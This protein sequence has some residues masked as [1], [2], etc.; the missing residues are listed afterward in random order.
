[1]LSIPMASVER[2][3]EVLG[4]ESTIVSPENGLTEVADGSITFDHV[5]F[6][7]TDENGDKAHVLSD[8][9]LSIRSGEVIGIIGDWFW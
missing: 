9:N 5:D 3:N 4:T 8:V 2:I 6:A 1:M 7:Y